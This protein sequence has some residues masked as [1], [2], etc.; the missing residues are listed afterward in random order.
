M[1]TINVTNEFISGK[2]GSESYNVPKSEEGMIFLKNLKDEYFVKL[3][4]I[5]TD[6]EYVQL[7][8]EYVEKIN[9][10]FDFK[11]T[12]KIM[13]DCEHLFVDRNGNFFLKN[14]DSILDVVIPE[15]IAN[16][17]L[18]DAR[19]GIDY[20]PL[21]KMVI[22]FMRKWRSTEKLSRL[23]SY[24]Q[25]PCIDKEYMKHL[26]EE[27][28]Y[29]EKVAKEAATRTECSITQEGIL[30]TYKVVA[31]RNWTYEFDKDGN[32]IKTPLA[33]VTKN[34]DPMSGVVIEEVAELSAEE[35]IFEPYV[36]KNGDKFDCGNTKD[37]YYFKIGQ[38]A[39]LSDWSKVNCNDNVTCVKG[40]HVGNHSYNEGWKTK[41]T[42]MFE[43]FVD[44][45]EIGAIPLTDAMRVREF[46]P[47]R[48]INYA[49]KGF[50]H[51][52]DYAK[53]KDAEW[54]K[55]K[56]E[57]FKEEEEKIKKIADVKEQEANLLKNL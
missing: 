56:A 31:A 3:S 25:N 46:L 10:K 28:G 19:A 9:L 11:I 39:R 12:D 42:P 37:V 36:I 33:K 43:C 6:E 8:K 55:I 14:N 22:R 29:T 13:T 1:L 45:M 18:S 53:L 32:V 49:N 30:V 41:N 47:V 21:V 23:M 54:E 38:V 7:N 2:V 16:R 40:L 44:P 15:N 57:I 24:V 48:V 5:S 51:S 20:L 50:Y 17:I 27:K 26:I 35:A 34:V 52:S 4:T